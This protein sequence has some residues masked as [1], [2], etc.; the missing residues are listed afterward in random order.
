[1]K[2][3][4]ETERLILR[5]MTVDDAADL[6]EVLSDPESM[7]YY[8]APFDREKV[9]RWIRWCQDSYRQH[10]YGLWAV[11]RKDTGECIGDCGISIQEIDGQDIPEIGYHVK[12][13][14]CTR[15][16][17]TEAAVAARRYG[18]KVLGFRRIVSYMTP[19]NLGSRR[20]AEK[21]GMTWVKG[22]EK[23]GKPQVLYEIRSEAEYAP[24][25][26]GPRV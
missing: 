14:W 4:L 11:V 17:A 24:S 20:V 18:F 8:P 23:N 12:P 22:F 10:G 1:M 15:G 9:L 13:K 19:D 16:Y 25:H 21:S 6:A 5:E 26:V 7:R 2:P 3:I